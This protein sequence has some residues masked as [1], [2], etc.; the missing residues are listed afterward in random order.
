MRRGAGKAEAFCG[1]GNRR[2]GVNSL[3]AK[4]RD[5]RARY[6]DLYC[7]R[8]AAVAVCRPGERGDD[9]GPVGD[10]SPG[11]GLPGR[12]NELL[13]ETR[14]TLADFGEKQPKRHFLRSSWMLVRIGG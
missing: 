14:G 11:P 8:G 7:G 13:A 3:P 5:A 9:G 10:Q 12:R 6:E 1:K 2:Y 4:E